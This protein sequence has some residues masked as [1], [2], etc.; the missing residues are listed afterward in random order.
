[1]AQHLDFQA[2]QHALTVLS[3]FHDNSCCVT[4]WSLFPCRCTPHKRRDLDNRQWA[5]Q[6]WCSK[7]GQGQVAGLLRGQ[8]TP[9]AGGR[10]L[11]HDN[12]HY[13]QHVAQCCEGSAFQEDVLCIVFVACGSPSKQAGLWWAGFKRAYA[14]GSADDARYVCVRC[15]TFAAMAEGCGK[16]EKRLAWSHSTRAGA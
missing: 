5:S 12:M 7:V 13:L 10:P 9:S 15:S 2:P 16:G 11:I 6:L 8:E 14:L 4:S 1:M 3:L